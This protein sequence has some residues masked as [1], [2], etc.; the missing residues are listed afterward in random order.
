MK[1][2]VEALT[3]ALGVKPPSGT[4]ATSDAEPPE[5]A[6]P[7][8]SSLGISITLSDLKGM[9]EIPRAVLCCCE[10]DTWVKPLTGEKSGLK[11]P[12]EITI[13]LG[14]LF[15]EGTKA[16]GIKDCAFTL[17]NGFL[18]LAEASEALILLALS[19]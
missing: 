4:G 15:G 14:D 2:F 19:S 13:W 9:P 3:A 12:G 7:C 1:G 6:E 5:R 17:I 16:V 10:D 18:E 8:T 11:E